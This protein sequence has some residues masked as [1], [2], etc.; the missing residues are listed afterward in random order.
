MSASL[1]FDDAFEPSPVDLDRD[2]VIVGSGSLADVVPEDAGL[3]ATHC[4]IMHTRSRWRILDLYSRQGTRLNGKSV[5]DAIL[6]S[7]DRI[8]LGKISAVFETTESEPPAKAG[9]IELQIGG[10]E[11][12][13]L[14][15]DSA[16]IGSWAGCDIVVEGAEAAQVLVVNAHGGA[17]ARAI[18]EAGVVIVNGRTSD[19]CALLD[20][21]VLQVGEERFT[22]RAPHLPRRSD[23]EPM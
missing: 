2:V 13:S 14:E 9:P 21:D 7:G 1:I 20:G 4:A 5:A 22:V 15:S 18:G 10:G 3:C 8:K 12:W 16:L 19:G 11:R 6:R 17:V 23:G